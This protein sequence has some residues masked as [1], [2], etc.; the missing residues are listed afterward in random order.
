M[1]ILRD[2]LQRLHDA[3]DD[4]NASG[5][6]GAD[7]SNCLLCEANTISSVRGVE[8]QP[9]CPILGAREALDVTA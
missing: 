3:I 4:L 2:A 5:I 6:L 1:T 9:R 7:E 8:H